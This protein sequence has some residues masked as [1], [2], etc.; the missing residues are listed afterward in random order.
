MKSGRGVSHILY[1]PDQRVFLC[2]GLAMLRGTGS[3]GWVAFLERTGALSKHKKAEG[4][5]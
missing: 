1:C 5:G 3:G 4:C 2:G